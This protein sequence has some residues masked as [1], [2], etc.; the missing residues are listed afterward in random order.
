MSTAQESSRTILARWLR[1]NFVGAV[2]IAVQLATLAFLRTGLHLHYIVATALAVEVAVIHNFIWHERYT[3]ADRGTQAVATRFITFNATNGA[4]S[5][6]GN[7]LMMKL[8]VDGA[9]LP[10]LPANVGAIAACSIANFLLSDRLVFRMAKLPAAKHACLRSA[11][12]G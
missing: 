9:R 3:W 6:V 12:G 2:G 5:I 10:Y 4:V 1:F 7:L 11:T 8:L